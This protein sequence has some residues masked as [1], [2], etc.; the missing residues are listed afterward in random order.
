MRSIVNLSRRMLFGAAVLLMSVWA[1][2]GLP[3]RAPE[4]RCHDMAPIEPGTVYFRQWLE[5]Q[6]VWSMRADGRGKVPLP[7]GVAGEPSCRLHNRHRWF[8]SVREVE[9]EKHPGGRRARALFAARDDGRVI[10][11]RLPPDLDPGPFLPRW[12]LHARD[13]LVSWVARR[14]GEDG[15][16]LEGGLYVANT[17]FDDKSNLVALEEQSVELL[18]AVPLAAIAGGSWNRDDASPNIEEHDWS[19]DGRQVVF[20]TSDDRLRLAEL[21]DETIR[22]LT[23]VPGYSPTWSPDGEWI[24]FQVR[25]AFGGIGLIRPDG[26]GFRSVL[27]H[28]TEGRLVAAHPVWSPSAH[29][30]ACQSVAARPSPAAEPCPIDVLVADRTGAD[31]RNLTLDLGDGVRPVAWRSDDDTS[32]PV[33]A[34]GL[35]LAQGVHPHDSHRP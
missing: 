18:L 26:T 32:R 1:V 13:G 4:V 24:A 15:R 3:R 5:P 8:L 30:L 14:C 22:D 7:E 29:H 28:C 19:P 27:T 33:V 16:V 35:A 9:E 6:R 20:V 34:R 21:A 25:R 23:A 31:Q 2:A 12:P 11:L 17:V 10:R